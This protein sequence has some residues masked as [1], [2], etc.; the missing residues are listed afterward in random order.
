MSSSSR[1]ARKAPEEVAME[2]PSEES[3]FDEDFNS[4]DGEDMDVDDGSE[5]GSDHGQG[6][7]QGKAK[8]N[9][10]KPKTRK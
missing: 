8:N 1:R 2:L 7:G 6:Q 4:A 10:E 9:K 3:E 5:E